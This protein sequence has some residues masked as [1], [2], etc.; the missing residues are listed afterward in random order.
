MDPTDAG[1]DDL[2]EKLQRWD[3]ECEAHWSSWRKEA[4]QLFDAYAGRQWDD[5][6]LERMR[7][8]KRV[9]ITIN[10]FAS[11]IDAVAGAEITDRQEVQYLPREVGDSGVNEA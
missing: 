6:D 9:P 2:L 11:I 7:E 5:R 1:Y 3:R 10:R 8:F 4:R